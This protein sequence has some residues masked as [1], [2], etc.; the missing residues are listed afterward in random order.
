MPQ[1]PMRELVSAT[2]KVPETSVRHLVTSAGSH[3]ARELAGLP[4][5]RSG[6]KVAFGSVARGTFTGRNQPPEGVVE[7][8]KAVPP[9]LS[10]GAP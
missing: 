3:C 1:D 7:I 2:R 4:E 10:D 6:S 8:L 9:T 5:P